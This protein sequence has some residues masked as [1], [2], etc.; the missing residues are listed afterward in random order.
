[1]NELQFYTSSIPDSNPNK[2][3]LIKQW[4]IKNKWG[5]QE[6]KEVVEAPVKEVK[7]KV[8]VEEDAP[9]ATTPEASESSDSGSGNL[10]SSLFGK[11]DFQKS[12]EKQ[13]KLNKE[14][15]K[16]KADYE[17]QMASL[18]KVSTKGST[19]SA[20]NSDYKWDVDDE[21][22]IQY[23]TKD[24]N[25]DDWVNLNKNNGSQ[26]AQINLAAAQ[27]ELGHR[28]DI[29]KKELEEARNQ[30]I[31]LGINQ[32]KGV[33]WETQT[34]APPMSEYIGDVIQE[35]I[36]QSPELTYY[37]AQ[38]NKLKEIELDRKELKDKSTRFAEENFEDQA[39][40]DQFI[41]KEL[42][43]FD[44]QY[45]AE[46]ELLGE[47]DGLTDLQASALAEIK[48]DTGNNAST[49]SIPQQ[50]GQYFN[51]LTK[52]AG[53]DFERNILWNKHGRCL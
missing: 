52:A 6:V 47:L 22:K 26:D 35:D 23:Y 44:E 53:L 38:K 46:I 8:V 4:K 28:D 19:Y 34:Y 14:Y 2:A 41:V 12:Y 29:T 36:E 50:L 49:F 16:N 43:N 31:D 15:E 5:Q 42:A 20:N 1:M 18:S 10:K 3:E 7:E 37:T 33:L 24:Q 11:S 17:A 32:E 48:K 51:S 40:K 9:A 25:T 27:L 13:D 39:S 45:R 21:N 30:P